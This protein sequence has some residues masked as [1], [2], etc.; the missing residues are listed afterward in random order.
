VIALALARFIWDLAAALPALPV[1]DRGTGLFAEHCSLCHA[2][3]GLTGTPQPLQ[4]VGT[5]PSLG[6]SAERGTGTYRVP[7]LRGVAQRS[8]LLHDGSLPGVASLMDPGRLDPAYTG[9]AHGPGPVP[10]HSFGFRAGPFSGARGVARDRSREPG[11]RPGAGGARQRARKNLRYADD[12]I[13]RSPL[14]WRAV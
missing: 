12:A 7:S 1:D 9:G 3:V 2:G 11:R 10:G 14:R 13:P 8:T 6:R 4:L 5:D